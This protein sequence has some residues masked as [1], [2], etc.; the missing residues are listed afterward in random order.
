MLAEAQNY[1][2]EHHDEAKLYV[3]GQEYNKRAFATAASDLAV[4]VDA[5][6]RRQLRWATAGGHRY[7]TVGSLQVELVVAPWGWRVVG[8]RW[9]DEVWR[10]D[11]SDRGP[12]AAAVARAV[13]ELRLIS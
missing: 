13:A 6:R 4:V 11:S 10:V 5:G 9:G 8:S 7:A 3:F 12:Q 2:R 1:L